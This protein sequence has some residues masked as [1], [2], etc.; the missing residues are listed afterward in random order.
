M[1]RVVAVPEPVTIVLLGL[2]GLMLR[3]RR[4]A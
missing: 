3:R 4:I 1:D 2:G